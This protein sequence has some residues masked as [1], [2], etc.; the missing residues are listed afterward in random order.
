M[1]IVKSF[2]IISRF[3]FGPSLKGVVLSGSPFS[4]N[5]SGAPMVDI[6]ALHQRLPVLGI[7]YGARRRAGK[8]VRREWKKT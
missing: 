4:V 1:C 5:D 8:V 6:A 3:E 7:C 2:P